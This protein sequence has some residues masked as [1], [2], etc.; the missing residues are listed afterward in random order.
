MTRTEQNE[1][2]ESVSENGMMHKVQV[3]LCFFPLFQDEE[4]QLLMFLLPHPAFT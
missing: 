1:N 2:R 4:S 3:G